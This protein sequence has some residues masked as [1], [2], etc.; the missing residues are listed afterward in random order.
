[1][2]IRCST[3]HACTIPL[4]RFYPFCVALLFYSRCFLLCIWAPLLSSNPSL[5]SSS[6]NYTVLSAFCFRR[7]VF[8][9]VSMGSARSYIRVVVPFALRTG[10]GSRSPMRGWV[11]LVSNDL[12]LRGLRHGLWVRFKIGLNPAEW[13]NSMCVRAYD[14]IYKGEQNV[15]GGGLFSTGAGQ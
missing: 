5:S 2:W 13:R 9:S 4:A 1:M 3:S 10:F 11:L 15:L 14:R 6:T 7:S 12:D 8:T